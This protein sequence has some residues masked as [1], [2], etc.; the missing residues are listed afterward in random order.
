M[1]DTRN[2]F[3]FHYKKAEM[4][5]L[6][7]YKDKEI[8]LKRIEGLKIMIFL[9]QKL[10]LET[11]YINPR[12][13]VI[14]IKCSLNLI[15]FFFSDISTQEC[16]KGIPKS[17]IRLLETAHQNFK[18]LVSD[19]PSYSKR[20]LGIALVYF[21]E[22]NLWH[23]ESLC[24]DILVNFVINAGN[25]HIL[26]EALEEL[27][28]K[29]S[30]SIN[31]LRV[32]ARSL[33]KVLRQKLFVI[34]NL[35][36]VM[37]ALDVIYSFF[38][39][40][41]QKEKENRPLAYGLKLCIEGVIENVSND[42]RLLIIESLLKA[43]FDTHEHDPLLYLG[44]ILQFASR[45]LQVG[46]Y[47]EILSDNILSDI[48]K[49]IKSPSIEHTILGHTILQFLMDRNSNKDTITLRI[50][51]LFYQHL[52]YPFKIPKLNEDDVDFMQDLREKFQETIMCCIMQHGVSTFLSKI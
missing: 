45:K 40:K 30:N 15:D 25:C 21:D 7:H 8:Y 9:K 33:H 35:K 22:C 28:N 51:R 37:L 34:V 19:L 24:E 47:N 10:K 12:K 1:Q 14:L 42:T 49:L 4:K 41:M 6:G 38:F 20:I 27:L 36:T 46:V 13:C 50:P 32:I 48:M 52:Q 43:V 2:S 23:Y 39:D 44:Q 26:F 18:D 31:K 3:F 11:I 29:G 5:C 17:K 16:I